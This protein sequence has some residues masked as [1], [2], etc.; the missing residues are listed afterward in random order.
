[1]CALA[2]YAE[3]HDNNFNLL[4][5]TAAS[6]V[7]G[8][9]CW[10]LSGG[11]DVA[12]PLYGL[13]GITMGGLAVQIFFGI[14][15]FLVAS[16]WTRNPRTVSFLAARILRIFPALFVVLVA[17][18]FVLGPA[19]TVL[20]LQEY[21]SSF[22]TWIY[23][24]TGLALL[25]APGGRL[26]GVFAEAPYPFTLNGSLWTLFFEVGLYCL[27]MAIGLIGWLRP[28]R[29]GI[30][31]LG[32][33]IAAAAVSLLP[34]ARTSAILANFALVTSPFLTGT[35]AWI[36]RDRISV[37]WPWPVLFVAVTT[38][39]LLLGMPATNP[40]FSMA[41]ASLAL[42]VAL[43]PGGHIRSF[44]HLGDY[45]YGIYIYAFPVQQTIASLF[46]RIGVGGLFAASFP[47]SLCLAIFSWHLIE[48]PAMRVR[49]RFTTKRT[50]HP[51]LYCNR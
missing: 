8:A 48:S 22:A 17:T 27:I 23:V 36:W 29:F 18:A 20:P 26:P 32:L 34:I 10:P 14:S 45:S 2:N 40:L 41:I 35:T 51:T 5:F 6:A 33:A 30:V 37:R 50:V 49:N 44:N 16:S 15:G 47:V 28:R 24:P 7:L 25:K 19:M 46:P 3:G 4:R 39:A 1:M 13:I 38:A 43:V 12:D 11:S 31:L 42:Y 9:H 21:F